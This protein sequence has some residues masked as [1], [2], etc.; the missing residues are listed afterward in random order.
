M[1]ISENECRKEFT[2]TERLEYARRL[3]LIEGAK[4]KERMSEGGRGGNSATP[5]GKTRDKVAEQ[6]GTSA[7]QLRQEQ[8]VA[9]NADLLDPADFADWDEGKLSTN[10]AYQRIRAAKEQAERERDDAREDNV[11]YQRDVQELQAEI[12]AL[13]KQNDELYQLANTQQV[14]ER[15]VVREVKPDDYDEMKRRVRELEGSNRLYT[16]DNESLRRQL[17]DA[18]SGAYDHERIMDA[19]KLEADM[20]RRKYSELNELAD[21]IAAINQFLSV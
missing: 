7:T 16:D 11:Q 12:A 10:R 5:S 15:E 6:L 18:Q 19:A 21:V 14:V 13:E 20:F 4:A 8:F 1:E 2:K 9:D 17:E 3:A